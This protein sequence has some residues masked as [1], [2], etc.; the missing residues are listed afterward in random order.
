[1]SQAIHLGGL[2]P[3]RWSGSGAKGL[4]SHPRAAK[5]AALGLMPLSDGIGVHTDSGE[6][7]D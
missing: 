3:R 7:P 6:F 4:V 1:M 5:A 2:G